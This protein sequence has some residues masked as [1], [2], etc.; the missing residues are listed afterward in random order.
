MVQEVP[1]PG[2]AFQAAGPGAYRRGDL[3]RPCAVFGT[4]AEPFPCHSAFQEMACLLDVFS[5]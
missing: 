5:G 4:L 1:V 2:N 3:W